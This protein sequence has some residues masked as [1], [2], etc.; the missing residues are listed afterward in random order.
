MRSSLPKALWVE[1]AVGLNGQA[2]WTA[3]AR[4]FSGAVDLRENRERV[5]PG[6]KGLVTDQRA[7]ES[8]RTSGG[9]LGSPSESAEGRRHER[10][11]DVAPVVRKESYR[12]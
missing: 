8:V 12:G 6:T 10:E 4:W 7:T 11:F 5:E 3:L 1:S 9:R 2:E